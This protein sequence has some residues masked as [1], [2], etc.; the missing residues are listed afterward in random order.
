MGAFEECA[1][2]L[3]GMRP[4]VENLPPWRPSRQRSAYPSIYRYVLRRR[5]KPT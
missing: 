5:S 4:F 2:D 1:L 3:E